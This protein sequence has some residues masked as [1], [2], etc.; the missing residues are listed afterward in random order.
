MNRELNFEQI[1]FQII[2]SAGEAKTN[3]INSIK[4]AKENKIFEA[5]LLISEAEKSMIEAEKAH[6]EV[7]V[8]EARGSKFIFPVIFMHAEDQ[9]L[10]TQTIILMAK[11]FIEI[12]D[13]F[14]NVKN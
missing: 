5:N 2:A 3:A 9:L 13:R 12:Y 14:N 8:E 4:L 1:S 7:V 10:T 6:M 11:E